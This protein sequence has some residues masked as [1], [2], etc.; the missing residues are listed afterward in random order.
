MLNASAIR[1]VASTLLHES[2]KRDSPLGVAHF[3][4]PKDYMLYILILLEQVNERA[5]SVSPHET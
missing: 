3:R 4:V 5:Y 1:Y 2:S